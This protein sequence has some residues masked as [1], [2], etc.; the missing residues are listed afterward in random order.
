MVTSAIIA[1][2]RHRG[3]PSSIARRSD[4]RASARSVKM[5][6]R[7]GLATELADEGRALAAD[8]I[9]RAL[10]LDPP[11]PVRVACA[12]V[13]A[14]TFDKIGAFVLDKKLLSTIIYIWYDGGELRP[15][16]VP[17]LQRR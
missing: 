9:N 11:E 14:Q 3:A 13:R 10:T 4:A 15:S 2:A 6:A 1:R 17:E 16:L 5:R 8:E 12:R 7:L